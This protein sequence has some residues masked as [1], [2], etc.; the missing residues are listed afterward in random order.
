M[1]YIRFLKVPRLVKTGK[2]DQR[3]VS[4]KITITTDLGESFLLADVGIEVLL[5]DSAGIVLEG[6]PIRYSWDGRNGMRALEVSIPVPK[7]QTGFVKMSIRPGDREYVVNSYADVLNTSSHGGIATV[8]SMPV[9]L[10]ANDVTEALAERRFVTESGNISIWEE[11]GESI[12]RH[13]WYDI[14]H[15]VRF[16]LS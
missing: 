11:T 2:G 12:A 8:Y 13:I 6:K 15:Q 9:N 10:D 1:H 3:I 5:E 4:A 14:S 7:R 16:S